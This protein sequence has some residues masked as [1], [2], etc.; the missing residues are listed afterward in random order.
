MGNT[1]T[2]EEDRYRRSLYTYVKRSIPFPTFATFDAPSREFCTPRRLSS[3]TP[4]QALVML[5]DT[6][7]VECAEALADRIDSELS[8]DS[9]QSLAQAYQ[10]VTGRIADA[11]TINTLNQLYEDTK[12][13]SPD[14]AWTVVAQV[15]LNLDESLTF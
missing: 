15:L 9:K 14:S 6:V 12:M 8:D 5:N 3:N 1:R 2:G 4:L 11:E 7:F 13:H 10:L